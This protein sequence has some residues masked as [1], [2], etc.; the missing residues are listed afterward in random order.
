VLVYVQGKVRG[1][2]N[3]FFVRPVPSVFDG[4][5]TSVSIGLFA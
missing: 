3:N 1:R 4:R 2:L 5:A